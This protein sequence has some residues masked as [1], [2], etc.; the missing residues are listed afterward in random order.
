MKLKYPRIEV[1]DYKISLPFNPP[2]QLF[3][4]QMGDSMLILRHCGIVFLREQRFSDYIYVK[5]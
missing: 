2:V 3:L 1:E 5:T 4:Y